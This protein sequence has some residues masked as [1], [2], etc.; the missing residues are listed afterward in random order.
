MQVWCDDE[1]IEHFK[2][3]MIAMVRQ[4]MEKKIYDKNLVTHD[5]DVKT[6]WYDTTWHDDDD[7]DDDDKMDTTT[8]SHY[9][10]KK[11]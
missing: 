4:S 10:I 9:D 6:T 8:H 7:D 11:K 1:M 3:D 5:N 2:Y